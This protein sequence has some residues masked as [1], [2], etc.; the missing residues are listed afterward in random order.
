MQASHG[1]QWNLA[2]AAAGAP[3]RSASP[4]SGWPRARPNC[5]TPVHRGTER[6]DWAEV[7]FVTGPGFGTPLVGLDGDTK[8]VP[9]QAPRTNETSIRISSKAR[10]ILIKPKGDG[11][12]TVLS[13]TTRTSSPGIAY[14]NLGLPGATAADRRKMDARLRRKRPQEAKARP[15]P[16]RIRHARRI[17]RRLD[18]KRYRRGWALIIDQIRQ[19]APQAS[20]LIVGP[21][22]A[23]RLP[24]FAGGAGAQACR[25]LNLQETAIYDRMTER[26]N[27]RLARWHSPPKLD[28]VR[29]AQR[30]TAAIAGAFYWD[31]A[32]SMGGPCSIPRLGL[33]H[34]ATRGAGPHYPDRSWRRPLRARPVRGAYGRVRRATS[35][36]FRPKRKR[37]PRWRRRRQPRRQP[38]KSARFD[39]LARAMRV[40]PPGRR[41]GALAGPPARGRA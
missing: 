38:T 13:V 35:A 26:A 7:T 6:F 37:L 36:L 8:L 2:S 3:A 27:E 21:P 39:R 30:R 34:A 32:K 16:D 11:P 41:S 4:G 24:G 23:A 14:S 1:G 31:W 18:V 10:E 28:A 19:S 12:V 33:G 5:V 20:I 40:T 9:T 29:A 22:D 17:R 15:D 25:A